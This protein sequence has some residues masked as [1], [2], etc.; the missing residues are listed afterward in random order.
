MTVSGPIWLKFDL[1]GNI[2]DVHITYELKK[3]RIKSIRKETGNIIFRCSRAA[4]SVVGSRIRPNF[5]LI[6]VFNNLI[7][8]KY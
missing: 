3:D 8:C 1:I 4:Y 6:Q 5:E 7:T 2:M